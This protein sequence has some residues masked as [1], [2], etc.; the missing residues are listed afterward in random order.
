MPFL[1]STIPLSDEED[2]SSF[3]CT[4]DEL[5]DYFH[6]DALRDHQNRYT[7]THLVKHEEKIL[8]FY[9]LITDTIQIERI[10][11]SLLLEYDYR[12]IPAVKIARMATHRD[13]E[14]QGIGEYMITDLFW[15]IVSLTDDVGCSVITVDAKKES[16]RF[17]EKYAFQRA[18]TKADQDT[19]AMYLILNIK[20]M[21]EDPDDL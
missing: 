6:Q 8:G 9:S 20:Q 16:V 18:K 1:L 19:V 14:R 12:K 17:Y 21:T 2:L 10:D 4:N 13:S 15:R 3:S 11:E 7:I 5:N